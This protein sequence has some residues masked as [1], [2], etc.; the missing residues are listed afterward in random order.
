M[1]NRFFKNIL[2]SEDVNQGL[3]MLIEGQKLMVFKEKTV[4]NILTLIE[5]WQRFF[6]EIFNIRADFSD[7]SIPP[8][9]DEFVWPICVPGGMTTE[10]AF[11]GGE[12]QFPIEKRIKK[13]TNEL[14]DDVLDC[15][16]GREI[17]RN[18]YIVRVHPNIEADGDLK[19]LSADDIATRK[20]NTLTLKERFLLG[21]FLYWKEKIILDREMVT[22]CAGSRYSDGYVPSVCWYV[23]RLE[24]HWDS[25]DSRYDHLRARRAV[26]V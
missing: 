26:S 14:L 10:Q 22:L 5:D 25:S 9:P 15:S 24:V 2:N 23:G 1:E 16:F 4:S 19:N 8:A 11:S 20:I 7:V 12:L 21:R 3:Q 6:Y 13:R 17:L 18:S